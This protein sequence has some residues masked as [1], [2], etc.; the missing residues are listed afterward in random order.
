MKQTI[1]TI[2]IA[3][4]ALMTS[5]GAFAQTSFSV[6]VYDSNNDE[7]Q[8]AKVDLV[9]DGATVISATTD[10]WG[11]CDIET[12]ETLEG[13][14][15]LRASCEGYATQTLDVTLPTDSRSF[16]FNLVSTSAT[17]SLTV[18]EDGESQ[19]YWEG[20]RC[21]LSLGGATVAETT[22]GAYSMGM[23]ELTVANPDED[24]DYLLT[25][26]KEGYITVTRNLRLTAGETQELTVTLYKEGTEP[27]ADETVVSGNVYENGGS[28]RGIEGAT[29]SLL[30]GNTS[31]GTATTDSAGDFTITVDRLLEGTYTLTAVADGFKEASRSVTI[32]GGESKSNDIG[33]TKAASDATL[34]GEVKDAE[35][36]RSIVG[37]TLSI[38]QNDQLIATAVSEAWIGYSLV[39]PAVN[40]GDY[41]LTV[42]AD[43]YKDWSDTALHLTEGQN[44]LIVTMEKNTVQTENTIVRG[45][46]VNTS[47]RALSGAK[48][49]LYRADERLD[50][51][52]TGSDGTYEI[53]IAEKLDGNFTLTVN[54]DGYKNT[55][56][57]ITIIDG[58]AP[59]TEIVVARQTAILKATVKNLKTGAPVAN[60]RMVLEYAWEEV[61]SAVTDAAGE[62][63]ITVEGA[64]TDAY[65]LYITASNYKNFSE[66][67]TLADGENVREF[68]I[69][70]DDSGVA[71]VNADG[72]SI[73]LS[74]NG[75][76]LK[77][78]APVYV[79]I[80]KIDGSRVAAL[81][82]E[83]EE[84]V[85]LQK[86]FYIVRTGDVIRKVN[87]K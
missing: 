56:V 63:E 46:V 68:L 24:S 1:Y 32:E 71:D 70:P 34:Y 82:V 14:Y 79:E 66:D 58:E 31:L 78:A 30:D 2:L 9:K 29:V 76:L 53:N 44:A 51:E 81:T 61:A 28:W 20:A 23:C 49:S 48:V 72:F 26:S 42:Q 59:V 64:T 65:Q 37:A 84:C 16:T 75:I 7:L 18:K 54:V 45:K 83:G 27:P 39:V 87:I 41:T 6:E 47:G 21:V 80:F 36:G 62:C 11:E 57:E 4:L 35:S 86:G 22:T 43:G 67:I 60:A 85:I 33:L 15:Q 12:E 19:W 52:F 10:R 17:L 77:S 8:G 25:V 13:L 74:Q 55:S 73:L 38:Y 40:D 3:V 69:E 50:Y 5:A